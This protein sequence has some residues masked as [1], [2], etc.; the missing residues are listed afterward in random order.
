MFKQP[1]TFSLLRLM[2]LIQEETGGESQVPL[3]LRGTNVTYK[4]NHVYESRE[5]M[6]YDWLCLEVKAYRGRKL[7]AFT[8]GGK[9]SGPHLEQPLVNAC[10]IKEVSGMLRR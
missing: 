6:L 10:F 8:I 2:E 1:K 4:C 5:Q 3:P 7:Q 9:S